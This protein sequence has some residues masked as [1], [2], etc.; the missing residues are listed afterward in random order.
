MTPA[1][2]QQPARAAQISEEDAVTRVKSFV[3]SNKSYDVPT[4]CVD[5]RSDGYKNVGYTINV[6]DLCGPQPRSLGHWRVD[7]L[8]RE[9][10]RQNGN[11][12][13]VRP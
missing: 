10:F 6:L 1:P 8:T 2:V 12:K 7:A 9:V 3:L 11:G 5:V 13:F 4:D